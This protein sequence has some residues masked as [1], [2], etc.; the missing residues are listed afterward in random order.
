MEMWLWGIIFLLC[1]CVAAL[2]IKVYVMRKSA[3]EMEKAFSERIHS[4]TNTLIDITSRDRRLC[5]LAVSMNVQL[6]ELRRQRRR[7]E[8][9]DR[10]LKEAVTNISHDLRTP[11]T[12]IYGYLDLLETEEKSEGVKQYLQII[13]NRTDVMRQLSEE[14][15][16]Y[17][18][19]A[20]TTPDLSYEELSLN[21]ALEESI[22]AYYAVLKHA[23]IQPEIT[24]PEKK[25]IR[26]LD[27]KAMARILSNVLSNAVKYSDGD[28]NI[29]LTEG[30]EIICANHTSKLNEVEVGKLF[31]RFY[32]VEDARKSTGL[33]LSIAKTLTEEMGGKIYAKYQNEC[34]AIHIV[35]ENRETVTYE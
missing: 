12:V 8:A 17:S 6:R 4:D 16:A 27:K 26:R 29:T 31:H 20:S 11:L 33:G 32:T 24:M 5:S 22:S 7:Y 18:I 13:R 9:G 10:E 2:S 25:I 28:L 1:M 34:V 14:L 3:G 19:V 23:K 15:F 35:F 30:G 21:S